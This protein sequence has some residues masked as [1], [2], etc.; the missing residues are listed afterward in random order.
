MKKLLFCALV[1]ALAA[2][3]TMLGPLTGLKEVVGSYLEILA[4]ARHR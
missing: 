4:P 3:G 2:G 1:I